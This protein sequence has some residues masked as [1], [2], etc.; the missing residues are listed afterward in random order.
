M[1]EVFDLV[2]FGGSGD[3][4]MRK[5]LPAMYRSYEQG[6]VP[7]NSKIMVCCRTQHDFDNMKHTIKDKLQKFLE[8]DS[9]SE[10]QWQ[11]FAYLIEPVLLDL[12]DLEKGWESFASKF[13]SN[14]DRIRVF[15]LAVVSSIYGIACDNLA[16][17]NLITENSRLIVE[18]PLGYDYPSAEA[19]NE[20]ISEYFEEDQIYRI[21]HYLGKDTVQNLLTLRFSN[22]LFENMWDSKAIDHIEISITEQVGL[23]GRSGFC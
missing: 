19:I 22:F 1:K 7:D 3:L 21:D 5:L 9:F 13:E 20:K 8:Q 23:E 14:P 6:N 10:E 4:S 15:Y 18:K 12:T 2:I 16:K 17:M 11:K